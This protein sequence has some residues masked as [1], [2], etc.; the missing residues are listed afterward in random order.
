MPPPTRDQNA[1]PLK[2]PEAG[3]PWGLIA[4]GA[5][6]F[7]LLTLPPLAIVALKAGRRRRRRRASAGAALVGS[8]DE[9]VDL[10]ADSGL[11][12]ELGRTRQETAWA[13]SSQWELGED[14]GDPFALV[15]DDTHRG[16]DAPTSSSDRGGTPDKRRYVIDGWSRFGGDVPAPVAIA[17]FAEQIGNTAA[18]SNVASPPHSGGMPLTTFKYAI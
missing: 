1:D 16:E 6:G 3:L 17:R 11:R 14:P 2:P 13:L 8:W 4:G 7:L 9:V 5:G 18:P 10:A 12:I 15:T